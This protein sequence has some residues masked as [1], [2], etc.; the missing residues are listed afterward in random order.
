MN[1]GLVSHFVKQGLSDIAKELLSR[2]TCQNREE[3]MLYLEKLDWGRLSQALGVTTVHV[4]ERDTHC[5]H[6]IRKAGEFQ[7]TWSVAAFLWE[8]QLHSEFSIG[9]HEKYLPSDASMVGDQGLIVLGTPAWNNCITSWVPS[10]P[11]D[12]ILIPHDECLTL[13]KFL[14]VHDSK[15]DVE[16]R[17]TVLFAYMPCKSSIESINDFRMN[18]YNDPIFT[19][20][21]GNSIVSGADEVGVLL[22]GHELG[23][24]W[25]GSRLDYERARSI[26]PESN[27]TSI[28]VAAG[29]LGALSWMIQNPLEGFKLPE[30]LPHEFILPLAKKYIEPFVSLHSDWSLP[31]SLDAS[32]CFIA[33]APWQ[34]TAMLKKS[35]VDNYILS[36][37]YKPAPTLNQSLL[38]M[39]ATDHDRE[40]KKDA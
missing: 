17:P 22:L 7:S 10:G 21:K 19:I 35:S 26:I 8:L 14:E 27:V 25:T 33:D 6:L 37:A 12:G 13:G 1:P 36:P 32:C 15:G 31:P 18:C 9:T 16:Y 23:A 39:Y 30:H 34:L 3:I 2:E 29:V 4:S 28:Q 20:L 40:E 5:S 38:N 11:I 24:W